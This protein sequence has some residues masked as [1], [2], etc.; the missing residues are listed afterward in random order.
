[1]RFD[2]S[3]YYNLLQVFDLAGRRIFG[4]EWQGDEVGARPVA[5]PNSIKKQRYEFRNKIAEL[6]GQIAPLQAQFGIDLD[7]E[8]AKETSEKLRPLKQKRSA[9]VLEFNNLPYLTESW[10]ASDN[11]FKRRMRVENELRAAFREEKLE[12][13]LSTA[14]VVKW[15]HWEEYSDFKV[16]FDLSMVRLPLSHTQQRRRA[17][18]FVRKPDLDAWLVRFGAAKI[19][20][21]PEERE[22][23][24]N[25][26]EDKVR[27]DKAKA[28]SKESYRAEAQRR[29]PSIT[30]R[31]FNS[32]WDQAVPEA[33]KQPGRTRTKS[34]KK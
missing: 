15:R 31:M 25:W 21:E 9:L 5:D 26:L 4:S 3:R 17:A 19:T 10:V 13:I 33:W 29:F 12:L 6:D 8:E 27:S 11:A 22:H 32:V 28:R 20:G 34:G 2:L 14:D 1:M 24:R 16:Y 18:G 23:L 30:I 7:I